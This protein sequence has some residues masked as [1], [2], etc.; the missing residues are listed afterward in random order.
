M[1]RKF[2]SVVLCVCMMLT[3]APFAFAEGVSSGGGGGGG[4]SSAATLQSKID[5]LG[6]EGGIVTLDNDYTET[7]TINTGKNITLDLNTIAF[8]PPLEM[9]L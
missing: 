5:A 6:S 4:G 9:Q 8:R 2:L 3:M 7:I 1:R